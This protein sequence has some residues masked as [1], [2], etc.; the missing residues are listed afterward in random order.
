[1]N[2]AALCCIFTTDRATALCFASVVCGKQYPT[3][4]NRQ[5]LFQNSL[6]LP[7]LALAALE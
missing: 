4:T 7:L 6:Q 3:R 2:D 5:G 1:M